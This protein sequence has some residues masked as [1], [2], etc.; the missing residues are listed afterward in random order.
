MDEPKDTLP[1]PAPC[2]CFAEIRDMLEKQNRAI[3]ELRAEVNQ[4][5]NYI[6][7]DALANAAELRRSGV[8]PEAWR[9]EPTSPGRRVPDY[10]GDPGHG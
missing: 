5:I 8:P 7:R 9:E 2:N 3:A 10:D 4:C 6:Q 1:A